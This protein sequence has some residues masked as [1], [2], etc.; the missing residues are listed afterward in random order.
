[1]DTHVANACCVFGAM[2]GR[3]SRWVASGGLLATAL[4]LW[5]CA[6]S[7]PALAQATC[8]TVVVTGGTGSV[9]S[10]T[11]TFSVPPGT[12]DGTYF[13]CDNGNGT[14]TIGGPGVPGGSCTGPIPSGSNVA[15]FVTAISACVSAGGALP[16]ATAANAARA[17]AQS[18]LNVVQLQVQKLRDQVRV[19]TSAPSSR[20]L[21]FAG[22]PNDDAAR[23]LPERLSAYGRRAEKAPVF[24][25]AQALASGAPVVK[26]TTWAVGFYDRDRRDEI[27]KDAD[28]GRTTQ[29]GGGIG[30]VF[31]MIT[32]FNLPYSEPG[33]IIMLGAFGG[34]AA[35][36]V[37]NDIPSTSNVIGPGFG[38]TAIWMRGSFS[39]D[40][41][42]KADFFEIEMS[43]LG[44][45]RLRMGVHN[46]TTNLNY[47]I[48]RGK[49]WAEPTGAFGYTRT[50]WD[51]R[52]N[53][54]GFVHG[55]QVR[56]TAG[57][58]FGTSWDWK[59]V[60]ID[61][62][63]GL[64]LYDD[65]VVRG[66]TLGPS[67]ANGLIKTDESRLFGQATGK[68]TFDWGRGLSSY[69]ESEIR[70]RNGAL[71]L[72]GKLGVTYNWD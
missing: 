34:A 24:E 37:N 36:H 31:A 61:P 70:G 60:R 32:G 44:S 1:L 21:G 48:E 25:A 6:S 47:R 53:D 71:G 18:G 27:F 11:I 45:T 28:L 39:V 46:S 15:G 66:G 2:V 59:G 33:D 14:G 49:W 63:V 50:E 3:A 12:P 29:T 16:F 42:Y 19:Q 54:L 9:P 35:S 17:A 26:Y 30:G 52:T 40:S 72:A 67:L 64:Y 65:I 23:D 62:V 51:G 69:I 41:T 56:L 20:P 5:L 58:R 4:I 8:I 55:D 57:S 38:L 22:Q 7:A 43:T 68:A 13:A 10:T